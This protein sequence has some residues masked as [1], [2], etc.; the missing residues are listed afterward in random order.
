MTLNEKRLNNTARDV[1]RNYSLSNH[2]I[3]NLFLLF[4]NSGSSSVLADIILNTVIRITKY[5]SCIQCG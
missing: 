2:D 4:F 3:F 5:K 1:F